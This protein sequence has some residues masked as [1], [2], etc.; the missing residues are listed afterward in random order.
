MKHN[1]LTRVPLVEEDFHGVFYFAHI[2]FLRA[3]NKGK[4]VLAVYNDP[5]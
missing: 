4:K 2:F 5:I 3:G 1:K